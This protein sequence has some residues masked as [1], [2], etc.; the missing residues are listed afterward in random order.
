MPLEKNDKDKEKK[1][2]CS[3]RKLTN[4]LQ[5]NINLNDSVFLIKDYRD[6]KEVSQHVERGEVNKLSTQKS[7]SNKNVFQE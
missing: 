3:W 4:Y 2:L 1:Y 5:T 6:Q 7:I